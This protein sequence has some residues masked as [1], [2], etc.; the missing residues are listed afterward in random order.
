MLR[1]AGPLGSSLSSPSFFSISSLSF[2]HDRSLFRSVLHPLRSF[3]APFCSSRLSFPF[4]CFIFAPHKNSSPSFPPQGRGRFFTSMR[5]VVSGALAALCANDIPNCNHAKIQAALHLAF[6]V[7][8]NLILTLCLLRSSLRS[9]ANKILDQVTALHGPLHGRSGLFTS[10][11]ALNR[12]Y[13][14]G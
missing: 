9:C 14:I 1:S 11:Y 8:R 10:S 6:S 7:N 13:S 3:S 2:S 5:N 4:F 12:S